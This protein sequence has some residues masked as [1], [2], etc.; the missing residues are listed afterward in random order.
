MIYRTSSGRVSSGEAIGIL[1]LDTVVPFIPGDVA[2]ATSY[3]FPVRFGT[4]PGFTVA[5]AIG[6]D[7]TVYPQLKDAAAELV[8]QG[9]RAI[10]GDCGYLALHQR[11]LATEL[12]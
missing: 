10:T 7:P 3:D 4:I 11:R 12:G 5:R 2:N 1:L 6:K 9:V 8:R